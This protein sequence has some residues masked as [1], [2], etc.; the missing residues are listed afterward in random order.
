MPHWLCSKNGRK[1]LRSDSAT[2]P[3]PASR[4]WRWRWATIS[5]FPLLQFLPL[6]FKH[7]ANTIQHFLLLF[8]TLA[9]LDAVGR[10]DDDGFMNN[11]LLIVPANRHVA[12]KA[13]VSRS[14][15]WWDEWGAVMTYI[16]LKESY[17]A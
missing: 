8:G 12:V 1:Q 17:I 4:R 2:F 5:F 7:F 11:H 14:E 15:A 3:Q 9:I 6:S 13:R 16:L 10:G